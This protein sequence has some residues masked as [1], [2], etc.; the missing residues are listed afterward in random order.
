MEGPFVE[1]HFDL[2][3]HFDPVS[4]N[5]LIL[6][7]AFTLV[8]IIPRFTPQL[9]VNTLPICRRNVL[10]PKSRISNNLYEVFEARL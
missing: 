6:P 8:A 10:R 1:R 7:T 3:R 9:C 2:D 4:I 5:G